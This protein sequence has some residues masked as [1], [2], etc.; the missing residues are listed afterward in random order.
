MGW[1]E[2]DPAATSSCPKPITSVTERKWPPEATQQIINIYQWCE[3][4]DWCEG[5]QRGM[6]PG[7]DHTSVL[8]SVAD[9]GGGGGGIQRAG[10]FTM[11]G[12]DKK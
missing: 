9:S 11:S 5:C 1:G 2:G 7:A 4:C 8:L 12:A 6:G 10:H 3:L